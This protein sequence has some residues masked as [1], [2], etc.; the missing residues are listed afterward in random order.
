[1]GCVKYRRELGVIKNRIR[2]LTRAGPSGNDPG[3]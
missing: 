2:F 3:L 1:M